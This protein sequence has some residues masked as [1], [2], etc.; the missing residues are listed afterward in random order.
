MQQLIDYGKA[1][2]LQELYGSVLADNSTMLHV[3]REL[4]FTV[5]VEPGEKRVRRV[6]LKPS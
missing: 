4:G 3:C 5:G 1:E 6:V 2:G